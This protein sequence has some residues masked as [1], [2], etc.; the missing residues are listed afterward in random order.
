MN[1]V[2]PASVNNNTRRDHGEGQGSGFSSSGPVLL[3]LPGLLLLAACAP[4]IEDVINPTGATVAT[5]PI[6]GPAKAISDRPPPNLS[7]YP[8]KDSTVAIL[9]FDVR[10]GISA[11]EVAL[12][13]DRFEVEFGKVNVQK[14]V[15]RSKMKQVLELQKFA[16]TCGS[17]ECAIE[18]GQLLNVEYMIYGSVGRIN[19]LNT[20]NIY[21]TSVERGEVVA[22]STTDYEGS[23]EGLIKNGARQAVNGFL[24]S[25][26]AKVP[27]QQSAGGQ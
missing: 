21:M 9:T 17:T 11:E 4:L 1:T 7:K 6:T 26:M 20:I 27:K 5:P 14:V 12:L 16:A 24:R 19:R 3:L 10:A 13:A 18:A 22:S 8:F 2:R 15:S 23:P 25:V